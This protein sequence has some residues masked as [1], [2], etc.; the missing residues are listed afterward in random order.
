MLVALAPSPSGGYHRHGMAVSQEARLLHESE[1]PVE[2]LPGC[3]VQWLVDQ[4]L[5]AEHL[6]SFICT[7][8]QQR[9]SAH[10]HPGAEEVLYVLAGKGHVW[11]EGVRHDVT[12]G[13]ALLIPDGAEHALENTGETMLRV[14]GGMA[15][16][17]AK[18]RIQTLI[19][20][21]DAGDRAAA[22]PVDE[23]SVA[24][25]MM[26]ERSF[27]VLVD[28]RRGS[29]QMTQFTGIIPPGRAPLH[30][31]PHEE[32]VYILSGTGRFWVEDKVAGELRAGS[33]IFIP[34]GVRHTL[35][36][37]SEAELLKVLGTFSPAGS[38]DAKLPPS[39]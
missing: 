28:T 26:G 31:H 15:P 4:R 35:E 37:S 18:D 19:P 25:T 36:N 2:H 17:I 24:S 9:S 23:G 12:T 11:I 20:H 8:N 29:R 27:K 6:M 33:V 1:V 10:T 5:G 32:A 39:S 22:L 38:P 21:L 14:L 34:I 16:P 3:T 13:K 30:A 7:L